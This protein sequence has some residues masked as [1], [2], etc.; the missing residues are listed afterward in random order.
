MLSSD[1]ARFVNVLAGQTGL[2]PAVVAAWV[3][4][5]SAPG[6]TELGHDY[7]DTSRSAPTAGHAAARWAKYLADHQPDVMGSRPAGAPAQLR[8]IATSPTLPS[9]SYSELLHNWVG[10]RRAEMAGTL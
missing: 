10:T 1:Q 7:I 4:S 9:G 8:E 3:I 2:E 6:A 5:N